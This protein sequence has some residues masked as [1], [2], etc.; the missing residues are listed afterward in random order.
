MGTKVTIPP[1]TLPD[2]SSFVPQL[3]EAMEKVSAEF[4]KV[5]YRDGSQSAT[6]NQNMAGRRIYNLPQPEGPS[7]PLRLEDLVRFLAGE[8]LPTLNSSV[9]ALLDK[10]SSFVANLTDLAAAPRNSPVFVTDNHVAGVFVF[11]SGNYTSRLA[12]DTQKAIFVAPSDGTAGAWVRQ[13]S[14]VANLQWFGG[15]GDN[16]TNCDTAFAAAVALFNAGHINGIYLPAGNY[17]V[18]TAIPAITRT[19]FILAGDGSRNSVIEQTANANTLHLTSTSPLLQ[20]IS[21]VTFFRVGINQGNVTSPTAG[22]ALRLTRVDRLMSLD[23]DIRNAFQGILFEGGAD[24]KFSNIVVTGAFSWNSVAVGS[25][26]VKFTNFAGTTEVPS[27]I[28]FS[29]FNIKGVTNLE[30]SVVIECCDG[31]FFSNGHVGFAHSSST[32]LNPQN[33]ASLSLINVEFNNVYFDGN[34]AGSVAGSGIDI[35]GSITPTFR[36][37]HFSNCVF[38]NF[39]GI[40]FSANTTNLRDL[41]IIGCQFADHGKQHLKLDG[42]RGVRLGM[43]SFYN[44]NL[45][46]TVTGSVN[47]DIGLNCANITFVGNQQTDGLMSVVAVDGFTMPMGFD[48]VEITGI[49]SVSNINATNMKGQKVTLLFTGTPT[50]NDNSGNMRLA[51]NF[52]ATP[53]SVLT[54]LNNGIHWVEVS[55]AIV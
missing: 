42:P 12:V 41:S 45:S 52:V 28:F 21:D 25:Y 44:G 7:E 49:S 53:G 9:L 37:I 30:R 22:V 14:G 39:N 36:G 5:A 55:R 35:S 54:L 38:K 43:N 11:Q 27:E 4:D 8:G 40:G 1:L 32:H 33:S 17:R 13:F 24:Q 51:G 10:K 23:L 31:L 46:G 34:L 3:N 29:N 6:G 20:R 15:R 47:M 18:T 48:V 26:N 2:N 50:F 16:N 19:G